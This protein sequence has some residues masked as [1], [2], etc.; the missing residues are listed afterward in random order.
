MGT[1]RKG[2]QFLKKKYVRLKTQNLSR[3]IAVDNTTCVD[4][5]KRIGVTPTY[6]TMLLKGK[7]NP[8]PNVRQKL[9]DEFKES[10]WENL[11]EYTSH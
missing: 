5:A 2:K 4:L 11:F 7:R 3:Y 10:K 8:G 9:M 1:F 6:I